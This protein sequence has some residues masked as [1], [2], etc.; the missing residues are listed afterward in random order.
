MKT[1]RELANNIVMNIG[2]GVVE[3]AM[4]SAKLSA[5]SACRIGFYEFKQPKELKKFKKNCPK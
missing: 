4:W 2:K 1:G 3:F 5:N